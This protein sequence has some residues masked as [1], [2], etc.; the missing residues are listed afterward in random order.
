MKNRQLEYEVRGGVVPYPNS[1]K[2]APAAVVMA[3]SRAGPVRE[4]MV[5]GLYEVS[6]AGTI[7][8]FVALETS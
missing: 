4:D 5:G 7:I 6:V 1:K 8:W 2:P 3:Q